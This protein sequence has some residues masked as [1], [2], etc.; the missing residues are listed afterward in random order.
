[1]IFFPRNFLPLQSKIRFLFI[2]SLVFIVPAV[3]SQS[4]A[5][6]LLKIDAEEQFNFAEHHFSNGEFEQAINEYH[7]F[8][9]FFP[10]DGRVETAMYKIGMSY[11]STKRF[12]AAIDSFQTLI[13]KYVET[14][15]SVKSY[16][17]ISRCHMALNQPGFAVANLHNI[18]AIIDKVEVRDEAYYRIG[19]IYLETAS[20]ENAR[21]YFK[22]ISLENQSKYRLKMISEELEKEKQIA[23]K[24][25][26]LAGFLSILPGAGQFYCE[27]YQDALV[28]FFLNIGLIVAACESF[29][30]EMYALGGVISFVELGFYA[31]NIH[32]AVSGAH[33]YNKVKETDFIE[34]LKQNTRIN[35]LSDHKNESII[36]SFQYCF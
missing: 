33:K 15:L 23:R 28:A 27:R 9:Y 13:D 34:K 32:G 17:M 1:M 4:Y 29:D 6:P 8:I 24:N 19:W 25:P 35:F 21:L 11:L 10:E 18:I 12:K 30:K 14:D 22:K 7:R 36:F 2:F 16:W 5:L 3:C 31:G 26:R 20:W